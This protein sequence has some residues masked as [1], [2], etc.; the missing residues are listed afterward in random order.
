M[1]EVAFPPKQF[2]RYCIIAEV[3]GACNLETLTSPYLSFCRAEKGLSANTLESYRRDLLRLEAFLAPLSLREVTLELLRSYVDSL[4][5]ARLSNR[6]ITRHIATLRGFFRYLLE[7]KHIASDPT[8]LLAAPK[9][10]SSLPKYLDDSRVDQLLEAPEGDTVLG[11]RDRA[12]IELL[13]A[14]GLRVSELIQL[15]ISDLDD[16][17]GVVRVT[18]KGDKQRLVP[19]GA[20]ALQAVEAYCAGQRERL[21][22][23]RVSPFLFVTARGTRM[24]RQGFW[25]LLRGHGKEAGVFKSLSPH[26]LRHTFATHL[27]EG[28]ADLRSV[29]IMLGHADIG[30]TQIYTHVMRSHLKETVDRH[31]PRGRSNAVRTRALREGEA[32][33]A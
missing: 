32:N 11:L 14:T 4:R 21:L 1:W 29:Q 17:A 31:H 5:D 23:G 30:T 6:T 28:G 25:K 26:V 19:V 33:P 8:E 16:A 22:R 9:S 20:R 10:S 3:E 13:Y 2:R 18:G 24:T 27:L 15:K 12:M 7:E